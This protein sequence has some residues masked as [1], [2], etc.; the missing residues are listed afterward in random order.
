MKIE[1]Q[2]D[3]WLSSAK[4][5]LDTAELLIGSG[6]IMHGLFFCHLSIEKSFKAV[7]VKIKKSIPPKTHNLIYLIDKMSLNINESDEEF[8][9]VLMKYQL[10]GRYPD[11]NPSLPS[12]EKAKE[13]FDKTKELLKWLKNQL[14]K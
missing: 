10:E 12:K 13:Y 7:Y 6:K 3:Y 14:S 9:G 1:Q 8:L 11:Y 4:D 5:D 2:I